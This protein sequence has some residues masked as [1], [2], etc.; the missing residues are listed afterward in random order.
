MGYNDDNTFVFRVD[1]LLD[2]QHMARGPETVIVRGWL[3]DVPLPLACPLEPLPTPPPDSPFERCGYAWVT[4]AE[5]QPVTVTANGSSFAAPPN[6]L[7]VQPAAYTEFASDPA[8]EA[9]DVAHVPRFG[10]YLLRLVSDP[11]SASN[12]GRGW[13]VVARLDPL[14]A[15]PPPS[16]TVASG[17]AATASATAL[18]YESARAAGNWQQAWALLSDYSRHQAGSLAAY[19]QGQTAYNGAGGTS[20][21]M[22][23][24]T[25]DPDLISPT[26]LGD[27]YADVVTHGDIRRAWLV[28]VEHP[29]VNGASAGSEALLVAPVGARWLVWIAH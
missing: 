18:A 27:V 16:P 13:Q 8:F 7:R 28:T 6:A 11:S 9:N 29:R 22:T 24:P 10:T 14:P 23:S 12:P 19:E 21:T 3:I 17:D 15:S 2:P 26:Y 25:Q 4:T 1:Q 5:I 20:F